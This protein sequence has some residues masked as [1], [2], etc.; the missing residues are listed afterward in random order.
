MEDRPIQNT[1][2]EDASNPRAE[3]QKEKGSFFTIFFITF[4]IAL[5]IRVFIA[6]PFVVNGASM[7]PTFETS[8]YLIVD[9]LSYRFREPLRGEVIIF[10]FPQDTSKFFIKR[11]VALPGETVEIRNNKITITHED[12]SS[13]TSEDAYL[14]WPTSG[15]TK[16]TLA[17]E[18]YFVLGDNRTVSSDSRQWGPVIEDLIVGRAFMRFLPI[19]DLNYLPGILPE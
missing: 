2:H 10:K 4:L 7:E 14:T 16:V 18:E 12:G 13:I 9:E 17:D 15:S 11:I 3:E 1:L 19:T 6:Q 5:F 8:E